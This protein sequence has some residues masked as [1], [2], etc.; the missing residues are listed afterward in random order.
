MT[1]PKSV[2]IIRLSAMGDVAMTSPI[3]HELCQQ[4]PDCRFTFLSTGFFKPFF[5]EHSNFRFFGTDIKKSGKG[6]R[7]IIKLYRELRQLEDFDLVIDIHNVLRTK[8]LSLLFRLTGVKVLVMDKGRQEKRALVRKDNKQLRPLMGTIDRY[9]SIVRE[10][11]LNLTLKN[12]FPLAGLTLSDKVQDLVG[13]K[14]CSWI[15]IAPFAQHKGKI[16]PLEAMEEVVRLLNE[17]GNVRLFV[18]GGGASERAVAESLEAKFENCVSVIG[19]LK[20]NEELELISKLD[21]M[22]S[23]DS[24]AMHMASLAGV[25][26]VSVWG[27]THP[28][29]GFLGYKQEYGDAVQLDLDCR[30]CSVYGNKP[31][32]KGTY[33]CMA[34]PPARIVDKIFEK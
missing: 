34:I 13:K 2:L 19:K 27:A 21:C 11:G 3:V 7:G 29:A 16:Y 26:V 1:K 32:Y 18:F 4:N 10:A 24:S 9:A 6:L 14:A 12:E 8:I 20:L 15:G 33:E 17:R 31:C 25:R 30:P 5:K 22:V 23:M 28:Y